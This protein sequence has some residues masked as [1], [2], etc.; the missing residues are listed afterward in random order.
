MGAPRS[1]HQHDHFIRQLARALNARLANAVFSEAF[2]LSRNELVLLFSV[3]GETFTVHVI[4]RFHSGFL[5]FGSGAYAKGSNARHCFESLGGLKVTAVSS[6]SYNRSFVIHF[7]GGSGLIFKCYD[8]LINVL[9]LQHE[10]VTGMFRESIRNDR[11]YDAAEYEVKDPGMIARLDAI[12][13]DEGY[14]AIHRYEGLYHLS[15]A[16]GTGEPLFETSDPLEASSEFARYQLGALNFMEAQASKLAAIGA[17][18]KRTRKQLAHARQGL[19]RL[20]NESPYEETA[21]L[22]MA[23]LHAIEPGMEEVEL[24]NFYTGRQ[25]RVRLNGELSAADNAAYYYRKAKNKKTE[26]EQLEQKLLSLGEQLAGQEALLEQVQ[27]AANMRELKPLVREK[28]EKETVPFRR[29]THSGFEIWVGKSAANNDLLTQHYAH[30]N[31]L[32]LHAKDVSGS[33]TVI[34]HKAGKPFPKEL[35]EYA[36]QVAA[37]YSKHKGNTLAPVSYTLKKFVRKPKGAEPGQVLLDREEVIMVEPKLQ[38]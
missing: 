27:H 33:H 15:L 8:A 5:L 29:F 10:Q 36:A 6:H 21:N 20:F 9:L 17:G 30:K 26:Q 37:Y 2:T 12:P 16:R 18:L 11:E 38:E 31:D 19:E 34:R 35:I 32:W 13:V 14:Y 7:E 4:A 28:K 24:F 22:I 3:N 1:F 25:V 23:N